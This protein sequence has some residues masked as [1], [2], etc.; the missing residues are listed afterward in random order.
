MV[1]NNSVDDSVFYVLKIISKG[2]Q[3]VSRHLFLTVRHRV[4]LID[5]ELTSHG[6]NW[7]NKLQQTNVLNS[8]TSDSTK[9][10]EPLNKNI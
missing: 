3:S 8:N 10:M 9:N 4:I 7:T 1:Q 6:S 5:G 2:R